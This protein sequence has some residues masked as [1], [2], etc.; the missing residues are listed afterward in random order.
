M[1]P[2][3]IA[4]A[5]AP[6]T[7]RVTGICSGDIPAP[8]GVSV[9]MP[10]EVAPARPAVA[11]EIVRVAGVVPLP[12]LTESQLPPEVVDATAVKLKAA[13]MLVTLTDRLAGA[14]PP[15]DRKSGVE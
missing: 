6:V 15:T 13:P 1:P 14:A 12:G 5:P 8:P 2:A 3:V 7:V 10:W 11:A 4:G 9:T